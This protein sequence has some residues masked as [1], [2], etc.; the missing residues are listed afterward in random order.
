MML[1]LSDGIC[2][3]SNKTMGSDIAV[4]TLILPNER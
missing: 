1:L 3:C 2:R 4:N